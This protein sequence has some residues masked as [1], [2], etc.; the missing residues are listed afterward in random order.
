MEQEQVLIDRA[1]DTAIKRSSAWRRK[2]TLLILVPGIVSTITRT[3]IAELPE[4]GSLDR[5]RV[6][7]LVGLAPWTQQS[8]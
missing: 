1:I 4:L 8:G 5:K 6:A 3:L 7:M 2:E